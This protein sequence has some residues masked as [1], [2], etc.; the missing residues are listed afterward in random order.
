MPHV[1]PRAGMAWEA[2]PDRSLELRRLSDG[3]RL[4]RHEN[5]FAHLPSE[6]AALS[7]DGRWFVWGGASTELY[8]LNLADGRRE[9]L[10]GHRYDVASIVFTPDGQSFV[11]GGTDGL[12]IEWG[13][14][15]PHRSRELGRHLTS[16]G[17]MAFSPDGRVLASQ[18]PGLGL[19]LWHPKTLR[20]VG[21]LKLP[22]ESA[23]QWL[24]FSQEGNW[25]AARASD[26]TIRLLP[27]AGSNP[28]GEPPVGR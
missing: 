19:H 23:G 24:G 18:E 25:L 20:E 21:Y 16:V 1:E 6:F 13:T 22:D 15:A 7:P 9:R 28:L 8:I 4:A 2:L 11:S 5:V 27:V 26:G 3:L 14:A 10:N 12:I 17:Q